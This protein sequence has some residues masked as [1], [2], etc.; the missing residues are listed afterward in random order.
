MLMTAA[1]LRLP[2]VITVAEKKERIQ[3][4][5]YELGIEH[6]LDRRYGEIGERGISGG[7]KR[8][9]QI[10]CQLVTGPSIVFLDEPTS[11]LDAFNAL[12]VCRFLKQYAMRK[13]RTIILSIHQVA[14]PVLKGRRAD[15]DLRTAAVRHLPQLRPAHGAGWRPRSLLWGDRERQGLL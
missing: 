4:L 10:A 11:G 1:Q 13:R 3:G 8:R 12:T 7:E 14:P 9:V 5:A 15:S 2:E 6:I